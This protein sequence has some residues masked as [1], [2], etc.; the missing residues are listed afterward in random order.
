MIIDLRSDT[1]TRPTAGM[2]DA[3]MKAP[4]G[5]DVF[6]EDPTVNKLEALA[7]GL[8]GMEAALYCPTGTMSN[9]IAI[10]VHT[11]P[12][13]EVICD[14]TAHVYQYE[15]GGIAF[16]AG[17]QVKLLE[18][19]HGRMTAAQVLQGINPDDVHKAR[20]SLVCLENT[21]NRG[22]GGCYDLQAIQMIRQ[23]CDEHQLQLHLDG[24]RL[25]NALVARKESPHAHG[26]LFH[27]IS[28]CL[29]KGLG[30]PVGSILIGPGAFIKKARRIRKVFGGGMRQAGYM[31]AAGVYALENQVE[32]LAVDHEHALILAEALSKAPF[33]G[34]LLPV[35]TNIVIFEVNGNRSATGIVA[36]LKENNILAIAIAPTQVRL[37]LH[38]DISREMVEHTVR[39][40]GGI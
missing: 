34:S 29:N 33:T 6:G 40:I 18:G 28:V 36:Q 19:D 37:V 31:A 5:D 8:F 11:Q 7:A 27:S 25:F 16:N 1:V 14:R 32:R 21:A 17:A 24:A 13:D 35:E 10:K 12:G 30:C 26:A 22:G 15:G 4:V 9:Q 3:M 39:V 20:T 2:L 23:V 38:L